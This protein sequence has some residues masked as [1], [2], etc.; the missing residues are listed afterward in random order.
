MDCRSP[1]F[2]KFQDIEVTM[3]I[4]SLRLEMRL[5]IFFI[6]MACMQMQ[7]QNKPL[8][9]AV[10][11]LTHTHVHGVFG[12]ENRGDF[13]L[14]GVVEPNPDLARRYAEQYDYPL[15][16]IYPTTHALLEKVVPEAVA[17]FGSILEHLEVVETF[18]PLGIHVMVEKP[19]AVNP[20]H[21]RRMQ[22][23]VQKHGIHLLTNYET[24]WYPTT[25]ETY[26][27]VRR[28][29]SI[30]AIRKIV[31]RDGHRGP[32]KIGID[33]EFLNW[34]TDPVANG[35][36]ALVDFGCYGANLSTWLMGGR[37]PLRVTALTTQLQAE[38]NPRVEDESIM[39]L[40][41]GDAVSVVH[42]SWNWPIGRK[43]L[44]VYGL[45]GAIYADNRHD[46]RI[47]I[48]EGYDGFEERTVKLPERLAP[49]DDPFAFLAAVVRG[50]VLLDP[51]D[52]SSLE[53]N[54]LVVDILEAAKESSRTG[55]TVQLED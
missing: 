8:K 1:D 40:D 43:D 4:K 19:L 48:A 29:S 11:G 13:E 17:A 42:G 53:N 31:I 21:A 2:A 47:R 41:Y 37:R 16:R 36:G 49:F 34:L 10:I 26:R 50:E 18:A 44:E 32:V 7:G 25:H 20:D 45:T 3:D 12:S 23:L 46:L 24:T 35:G 30:G 52:L 51:V 28:D 15:E 33:P 39:L 38:N 22:A 5:L 54:M 6:L 27:L 9:L 55:R 14:V